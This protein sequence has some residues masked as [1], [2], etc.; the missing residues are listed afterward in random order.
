VGEG[1]VARP[2]VDGAADPRI[3]MN[4]V[5]VHLC[6][7]NQPDTSVVDVRVGTVEE[8]LGP[9]IYSWW[10][11]G[12]PR[13]RLWRTPNSCRRDPGPWQHLQ[14]SSRLRL[15]GDEEVEVDDG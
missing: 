10:P 6:S 4:E 9:P 3:P 7:L 11:D 13:Q 12:P 5:H 14:T 8:E 15:R 2:I 1:G